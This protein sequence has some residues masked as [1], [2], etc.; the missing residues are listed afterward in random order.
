M[1]SNY[2][3]YGTKITNSNK[4]CFQ[5]ILDNKV[6]S[7]RRVFNKQVCMVHRFTLTKT[8]ASEKKKEK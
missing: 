5:I 6:T 2:L 1:K 8:I 3:I 4:G 7:L